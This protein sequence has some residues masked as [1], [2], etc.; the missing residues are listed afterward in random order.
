[1]NSIKIVLCTRYDDVVFTLKSRKFLGLDSSIV[2]QDY[3]DEVINGK[4]KRTDKK[5]IE[6]IEKFGDSCTRPEGALK[7][8]EIPSDIEK[9][10]VMSEYYD[11]VHYEVI[12]EI[13]RV[14]H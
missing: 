7:I 11:G 10:D 4:E 5:L 9:W 6:L 12:V 2:A 8:V 14:F 1:L 3:F 13:G